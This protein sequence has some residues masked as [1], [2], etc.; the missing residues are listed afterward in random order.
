MLAS[1]RSPGSPSDRRTSS[2]SPATS[3]RGR[4]GS[5]SSSACSPSSARA[6][7]CSE[8]T[9]SRTAAIPFSQPIDLEEIE[10]LESATLLGDESVEVE[11]RGSRVQLVGV[12]PRTYAARQAHPDEL[13]DPEASLRIL[14]CHFP[15]IVQR[16][17]DVFHLVLA[18]HM[19]AGQITVPLP[20]RKL[21]LAHPRARYVAGL[22]RVG[23]T[24]LHV[25]SGLG[26]TFVPFRFFARPEVTELVVRS[27]AS[28]RE[29]RDLD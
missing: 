18:G 7:S 6:S 27:I 3:C 10:A 25:S 15:R 23:A 11:L 24:L 29:L 26:T 4:R 12:D 16:I 2:A 20:R 22:Y 21:H 19:H 9:T 1:R 5:R 17:P 14:L 8:T 13:V 28:G